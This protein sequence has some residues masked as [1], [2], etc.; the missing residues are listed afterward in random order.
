MPDAHDA[1]TQPTTGSQPS[2]PSDSGRTTPSRHPERASHD[3]AA[4]R[5]ILE[6]ALVGHVGVVDP[7][8]APVV[9]PVA[10][11]PDGDRV[12]LHGSTGSRLFRTLAAGAAT[13]LTVTH[14]DGLVLARSAFESSMNYRSLV[15]LGVARELAGDEKEHALRV[16]TDHLTPRRWDALR[17]MARRE[18][19]ATTVLALPLA[20]FSVKVRSGGSD[21]PAEDLDWPIWSGQV[22]VGLRAGTPIAEPGSDER[23]TPDLPAALRAGPRP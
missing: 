19:A 21:D 3:L 1:A 6:T 2:T 15:V 9:L 16:L 12:L 4:A 23:P 13:C 5:A 17:P 20:E 11:A 8:G 22:P 7:S 10:I 14:V 18:V